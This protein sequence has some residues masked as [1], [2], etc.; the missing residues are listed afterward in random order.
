[1]EYVC[2]IC[3]SLS[4]CIIK[5]QHCGEQMED[6]GVIQNYF[7]EYSPYLSREITEKLDGAPE[8]SCTH[9]FLCNKCK[10]DKRVVIKRIII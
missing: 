1:M 5:C 3:N 7:D 8:G 4:S 6:T 2:P 9:L 10:Y